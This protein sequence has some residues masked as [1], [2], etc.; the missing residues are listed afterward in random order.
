[1]NQQPSP[2][3]RTLH[4]RCHPLPRS[5]GEG[6]AKTPAYFPLPVQCRHH[7]GFA[8]ITVMLLLLLFTVS[9][10]GTLYNVQAGSKSA[11]FLRQEV[12]RFQQADGGAVSVL[13][14]MTAF[15]QTNVP[16]EVKDTDAYSVGLR[17]I[18]DSVRYPAGFSVLWK[19]VDVHETAASSDGKAEVEVVA[20]V[21]VAPAT[22]GNE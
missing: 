5:R 7:E 20:F 4:V 14:Y 12:V 11:G 22:Y 2:A 9:G 17:V 8:L 21:P 3:P 16:R 10:M 15:K 1:M 6:I 18:G 19:G 13:G